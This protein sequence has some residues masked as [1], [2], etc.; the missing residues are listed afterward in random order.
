MFCTLFAEY[1]RYDV[2]DG[3]GMCEHIPMRS[4]TVC[5]RVSA[6]LSHYV[7]PYKF[8]SFVG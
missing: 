7:G 1:P 5:I 6:L 3:C 4:G 2:E 8:D